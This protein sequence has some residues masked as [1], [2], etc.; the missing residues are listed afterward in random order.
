MHKVLLLAV[1]ACGSPAAA[2]DALVVVPHP[3][4]ALDARPDAPPVDAAFDPLACA[5]QPAPAT[6]LDPLPIHGTLFA[7]DHY[8]VAPV[9]GATVVVRRR[10][11]AG[12]LATLTTNASG[13]FA[14]S[15][16]S[17]GTPLD[18]YFT[19]DVAGYRSSRIDPGDALVGSEN[20]L[21][22][23]ATEAEI[24]RWYGDAGVSAS[25]GTLI[26]ATVDCAGDAISSSIA[27]APSPA[28]I[29][30][31]DDAHQR[32]DASLAAST[33]GFALVAGPSASV[34]VTAHAG[35]TT[36]PAQVIAAPANV[37]TVAVVTP[38]AR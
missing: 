29:A 37:L 11:D 24:A 9:A 15:L 33:N 38:H 35:A 4:A 28:G 19:V 36:F 32:W 22:V 6:A 5:G 14:T 3:D 10:A 27:V 7:I 21:L 2:P 31:Y 20:A 23:V 25:G 18:A 13:A 30:Y 8:Q 17:G 1:V 16:S 34:T 12:V 26:A